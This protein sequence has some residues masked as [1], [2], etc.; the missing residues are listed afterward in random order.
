MTSPLADRL[1]PRDITEV[2][3]QKHLLGDGKILRRIIEGEGFQR[4]PYL[5]QRQRRIISLIYH[6]LIAKSHSLFF[7]LSEGVA[8]RRVLYIVV[9]FIKDREDV[10]SVF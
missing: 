4:P 7:Y 8:Q 5:P 9:V 6:N 2:S 1:R 10:F 3:G